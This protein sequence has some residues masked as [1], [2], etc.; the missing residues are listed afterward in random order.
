MIESQQSICV[1]YGAEFLESNLDEKLGIA[2][3]VRVI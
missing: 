3:N 2:L 1:K